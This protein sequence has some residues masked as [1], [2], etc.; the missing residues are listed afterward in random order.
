MHRL[1]AD[2]K[3]VGNLTVGVAAEVSVVYHRTL[4]LRK[5]HEP[6]LQKEFTIGFIGAVGA[7]LGYVIADSQ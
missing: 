2:R 5:Q 7:F 1:P 6:L 3:N 4:T